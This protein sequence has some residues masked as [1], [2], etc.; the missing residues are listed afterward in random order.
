[1]KLSFGSIQRKG[2]ALYY[3]SRIHAQQNWT[4]LKTGDLR[5]A[6]V[7]ARLLVPADDGGQT[8]WLRQLVRLGEQ[9]R[10]APTDGDFLFPAA[11]RKRPTKPLTAA[12]RAVGIV[13]KGPARASFHSLRATFISLMD[14]AGIPPHVT[15]AITGHAG[16]G[17]HARYTQPSAETLRR[18]VLRAI[19]PLVVRNPLKQPIGASPD[20]QR[21]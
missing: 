17:M 18:A 2:R 11:A 5:L 9:A 21:A 7:R 10:Q 14:E 19:P 3:V 4:P 1:M 6:R 16:G 13:N 15:D 20:G 12:F 8:A